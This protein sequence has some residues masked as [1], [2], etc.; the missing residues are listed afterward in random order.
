MSTIVLKMANKFSFPLNLFGSK[1]RTNLLRLF[2]TN[3]RSRYYVRQ[4]QGML[5]VSVGSLHRELKH[6][7]SIGVLHSQQEG[8]LHFY[9]ANP[10]YP[11]FKELK[12][13]IAKTVGIE[14]SLKSALQ[15]LKGLKIAIIYGSFASGKERERSDIDLFLIGKVNEETLN[16]NLRRLERSLAREINYVIMEPSEFNEEVKKR[17]PF[18]LNILEEPKI[19]L[20]GK[21]DELKRLA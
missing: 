5:G 14:G 17:A 2:F 12:N 10:N 7:E 20:I 4:L 16:Q 9:S 1:I 3:P 8:N 21:E 11:L 6:L 13:I 15:E 19:F 18:V